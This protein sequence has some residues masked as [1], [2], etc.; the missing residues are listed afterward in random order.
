MAPLWGG[1]PFCGGGPERGGGGGTITNPRRRGVQYVRSARATSS[2][3][4]STSRRRPNT[5]SASRSSRCSSTTRPRARSATRRWSCPTRPAR[6]AGRP[7]SSDASY[8]NAPLATTGTAIATIGAQTMANFIDASSATITGNF[9]Q[10]P[11]RVQ[12]L[13]H[14]RAI[15]RRQHRRRLP[16]LGHHNLGDQRQLQRRHPRSQQLEH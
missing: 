2:T 1:R 4:S 14:W 5:S 9:P 13:R 7:G 8:A 3:R 10:R 16:E 6:S 15:W 12:C 11:G